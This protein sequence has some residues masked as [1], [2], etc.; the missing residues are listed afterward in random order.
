MVVKNEIMTKKEKPLIL[1]AYVGVF[2]MDT[3]DMREFMCDVEDSLNESKK[4]FSDEDILM[5][6]IPDYDDIGIRLECLNP[7]FISE[8][9]FNEIEIKLKETKKKLDQYLDE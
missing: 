1:V 7:V 8:D 3:E 4:L 6:I 9:Q 2:D 5:F